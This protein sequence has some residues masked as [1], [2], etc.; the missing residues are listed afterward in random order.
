MA[1]ILLLAYLP[2]LAWSLVGA[3]WT[4]WRHPFTLWF[5]GGYSLIIIHQLIF[6]RGVG[7]ATVMSGI[8]G[9]QM[10]A[11]F[12][13][14][15]WMKLPIWTVLIFLVASTA[16]LIAVRIHADSRGILPTKTHQGGH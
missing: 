14:H 9:A 11:A 16:L 7:G 1:L 12:A 13:L 6:R 8:G 15:T 3:G 5:L 10:A 2:F 4:L